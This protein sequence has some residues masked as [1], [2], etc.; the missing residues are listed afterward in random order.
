[1][2]QTFFVG[3]EHKRFEQLKT[4]SKTDICLVFGSTIVR[5]I[6]IEQS[7]KQP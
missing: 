6:S 1:M 4:N 2:A 7:C 3:D 5:P